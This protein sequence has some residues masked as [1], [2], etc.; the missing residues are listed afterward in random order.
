MR[1][2]PL[3]FLGLAAAPAAGADFAAHDLDADARIDRA[4]MRRGHFLRLWDGDGNGRLSPPEV[5]AAFVARWD[6][7]ADGH[8]DPE[9][10]YRAL[11]ATMDVDNNGGLDP[12]EFQALLL[13]LPAEGD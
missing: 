7:D 2:W 5:S 9:E 12:R 13:Q 1:V 8:L 4:E 11:L 10:F 3:A 6:W